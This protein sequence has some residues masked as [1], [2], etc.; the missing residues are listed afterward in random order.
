QLAIIY[1]STTASASRWTVDDIKIQISTTPPPPVIKVNKGAIPFGFIPANTTKVDSLNLSAL[2]LTG[3]VNLSTSG[4]FT[5]STD[6]VNFTTAITLLQANANNTTTKIFVKFTPTSNNQ[7]YTGSLSISSMG[8]TTLQISLSGN[9]IDP[10][11]TMEVVSWNIE[12]FSGPNGPTNDVL[13]EQNALVVMENLDADLY[14]CPEIVDTIAFKNLAES[15][16]SPG[17]FGYYISTYASGISN[18]SNTE[19]ANAQKLGF[20][21]RKSMVSPTSFGPLFYTTNMSDTLYNYWASGRFPLKMEAM[22]TINSITYPV[23]VILIHA[24]AQNS[25]DAYSRRKKAATALKQYLDSVKV[26]QRFI[27]MGDYNDDLD[28]T[29]ASSGDVDPSDF[30]NSSYKVLID[31]VAQY[32][33]LTLPLSLNGEKSTV[34]FNDV[35]DHFVVSNEMNSDYVAGSA[36][37][38]TSVESLI[39][40]FGSTTSDH[41]PVL[42]R[43]AF[44]NSPL[45]VEIIDLGVR[46]ENGAANLTW[47]TKHEVN[48]HHF[49]VLKSYDGGNWVNLGQ[50][51]STGNASSQINRY[52]FIDKSTLKEIQY[53]R[54]N[55]VDNDGNSKLTDI[56]SL[57]DLITSAFIDVFPNPVSGLLNIQSKV[58]ADINLSIYNSNGV[59][60]GSYP[61]IGKNK[62]EVDLTY[63]PAGIYFI[64]ISTA[65][66][67]EVKKVIKL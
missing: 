59:L 64:E 48:A 35:I 5:I 30:P 58:D 1:T 47:T 4:V 65:S 49:D 32:K 40:N 17:E 13:Q 43:F 37:I 25:A 54:L 6:N 9:T 50:V 10:A 33:A 45:P 31:D 63:R 19:Y 12:W 44:S 20:I 2:R 52:A 15:L 34:S 26:N 55:Q 36:Q 66:V 38:I 11:S 60:I 57:E 22:V 61:K 14:G 39:T 51:S 53:Y 23:S 8:V 3:N 67:L 21:Y 28:Q 27:I 41:Y 18:T 56:V 46:K 7:S 16:G 24:K 29:V 42:T 62:V